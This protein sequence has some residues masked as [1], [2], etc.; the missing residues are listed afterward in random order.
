MVFRRLASIGLGL[1]IFASLALAAD[2]SLIDDFNQYPYQWRASKSVKLS[3]LTIPPA[4]PLAL[5]GQTAPEGVLKVSGPLHVDVKWP[6]GQ[7]CHKNRYFDKNR[8]IEVA[9]LTTSAFDAKSVDYESLTLGHADEVHA[10]RHDGK[11]HDKHGDKHGGPRSHLEDVDR[12]RDLDLVGHFRC[13]DIDDLR[14]NDL[15]GLQG[16][17]KGGAPITSGD[18]TAALFRPIQGGQDWSVGD[19]LRFWFH[20]TGGG[21]AIRFQ[22]HDNRAPDPGPSSWK[23]VWKDEFNGPAGKL[24]DAR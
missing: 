7:F 16:L 17:T 8:V 3:Q 22:L 21:D 2:A 9:V 10:D 20:G 5:P 1:S 11:H 12:D 18:S 13:E 14:Y 15:P 6:S 24:P 4:D 23:L 19:G